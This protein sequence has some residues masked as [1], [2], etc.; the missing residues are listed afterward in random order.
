MKK[1]KYIGCFGGLLVLMTLSLSSC[2]KERMPL[3]EETQTLFSPR[4]DAS[5]K[6]FYLL[7]E[8]NMNTN[9]ASLDYVDFT[10]GKYERNRYAAVN[11]DA[12]GGLGDVGND[13]GI[14]G[15]KLYVV[16][17]ASNKVEVLDAE[18]GKK[19]KQ[20]DLLNGRYLAFHKGK[21]YVSAYL[22]QTGD[23]NAPNGI[24][25]EIDTAS[26]SII[27]QVEVGRQPEELAIVGDKL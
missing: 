2:R 5:P 25:A 15:S 8:G 19:I 9:K 4:P 16:V 23:P 21:V 6:G 13:A 12:V 1:M 3:E 22:G 17:N 7:N 14:Y 10:T 11:P 24:V 26:L 20:I 27:R 18:S